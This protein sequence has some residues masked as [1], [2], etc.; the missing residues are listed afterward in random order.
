[1]SEDL[2]VEVKD[3]FREHFNKYTRKA[4]QMLPELEKPHILDIGCG[5]GVPTIELAKLS[6]GEIVAID[7]NQSLLDKLNR[8]IEEEGFSGRV[9]TVK[10][11]LF[12]MDFPN[13]SF[14]VIWAEGSIW[15]IGLER[16]LKEWNRLLKPNGFLVVHDEIKTV[17]NKLKKIPGCG[18]KLIDC[19]SIPED[20]WWTEYYRPLEIRIEELY[21]KYENNSEALKILEKCQNEIDLV[22][23]NPKEHS[24]AF[25][26]MQKP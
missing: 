13:G 5:S 2:L 16:G 12:E 6:N 11:S 23:K 4:F 3:H 24:S 26:V 25:F 14:D 8:R 22:K 9:K 7:I 17:S 21:V 19:F 20:A 1:M 18:Y 15:I 10:C